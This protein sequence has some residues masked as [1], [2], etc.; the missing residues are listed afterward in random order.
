MNIE[1][2]EFLLEDL[3]SFWGVAYSNPDA[4]WTK[5]NGPYFKGKLPKKN[6]FI[7]KIGPA[8]FVNNEFKN[9]I[10]VDE[11]IVGMVSAYYEDGKL[12][13]W[14]DVGI[15]IYSTEKWQKGIGKVALKLWIN[16]VFSIVSLPHI[17]LTTWSGNLRMIGLAESLNLEKEAQ[18]RKVR[19]WQGKYWDSVKYGVLR[20]NW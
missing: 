12:E 5:W 15:V 17:G 2:R 19:F 1:I 6:E 11:Q 8:D 14:L 7:K 4:E 20:A 18:I 9:V 13:R 10:I 16:H 3:E